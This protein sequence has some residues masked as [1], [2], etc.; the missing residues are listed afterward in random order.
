MIVER[1]LAEILI[2]KFNHC[3]DQKYYENLTSWLN[4][5]RVR[6]IVTNIE[7]TKKPHMITEIIETSTNVYR[8]YALLN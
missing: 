2:Q 5:L 6:E 3:G 1:K 4:M 7:W 8:L